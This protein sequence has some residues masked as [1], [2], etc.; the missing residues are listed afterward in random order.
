M[1][2]VSVIIPTRNR[3][4]LLP[5]AIESARA[6]GTDV[7]VVVVDDASTDETAEVCR[8][9]NGIR[10]VRLERH[11]N[12]A[13]ARNI[14]VLNSRGEYITFLDDD[15]VRLEG[16][17]N[18]Q[19]EALCCA[20]RVGLIYGQALIA[21]QRGVVT[22][23]LYPAA[24]PQGDIFW[25]LLG[26]NFIPSGTPL[27]RRSCLLTTG[28][29][30]TSAP[31]IEDWDLWIRIA[32]L[33]PVSALEQPVMIWRKP[34]PSSGQF[35]SRA[36]RMVA[37]ST[38]H[39]RRKWLKLTRAAQA[40]QPMQDE[41]RRRFSEN[42]ASHLVCETASALVARQPLRAQRNALAALNLY[43]RESVRVAGGYALRL[44]KSGA[45]GRSPG[46]GEAAPLV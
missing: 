5:R 12:V 11:Q 44:L 6:A 35:T 19:V 14:G 45:K 42:M 17:I 1:P 25:E 39:F 46:T 36:D 33:Y 9:I 37:M 43:P 18:F 7:E 24:C 13:G 29:L 40:S 32:A 28:L 2:S 26:R 21:D 41:A 10:Y 22:D 4:Q 38:R 30:D 34:T 27:F 23:T 3:S 31:G 16:S 8:G 15:D 20:P